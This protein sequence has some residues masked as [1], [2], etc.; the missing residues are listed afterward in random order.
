M[1]ST[2]LSP[3]AV[4]VDMLRLWDVASSDPKHSPEVLI[5]TNFNL[6]VGETIVVGT[7]RIDSDRGFILLVTAASR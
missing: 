2:L 3:S 6:K 1:R 5:D 7:S 4:K